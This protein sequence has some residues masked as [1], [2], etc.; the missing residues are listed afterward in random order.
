[1]TGSQRLSRAQIV[2]ELSDLEVG[3]VL[4]TLMHDF[5]GS[6]IDG[7]GLHLFLQIPAVLPG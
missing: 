7:I 6:G 1:V 2:G 3:Q 5:I 4:A